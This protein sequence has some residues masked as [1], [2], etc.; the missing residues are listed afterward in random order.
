MGVSGNPRKAEFIADAVNKIIQTLIVTAS[1]DESVWKYYQIGAIGYGNIV[2]S[3]FDTLF[4]EQDLIWVDELANRP[5]TIEERVRRE[6]DGAGGVIEMPIKFPIWIEP[7]A[8]GQ[9][10]M[11]EALEKSREILEKWSNDHPMSYPPTVIN[12]TDGESTDGNPLENAVL[13]KKLRT[14]NG[15]LLLFTL[16]VSSNQSTSTIA[17][18]NVSEGL[19]DNPSRIMF[20]MSS[21]LTN[22]M[23]DT[24]NTNYTEKMKEGAKG[25]VYN[26]GIAEIVQLL[27]IGTRPANLR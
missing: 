8:R 23:I 4:G 24:I 22:K 16:H 20:E 9:T 13:L 7:A 21:N 14:S 19:P 26:A 10:P 2:S 25:F 12:L 1:K 6:S 15:D 18:P 27:D 3:A 5:I 17:Y 11:C